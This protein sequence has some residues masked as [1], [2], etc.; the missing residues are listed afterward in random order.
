MIWAQRQRLEIINKLK[1]TFVEA[2]ARN[3]A[4]DEN[5]LI[6]EICSTYGSTIRKAKEYIAN[7]IFSGFIQRKEFGLVLSEKFKPTSPK[8]ETPN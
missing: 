4:I 8:N 5:A 7:L 3:L 2:S 6:S 1:S